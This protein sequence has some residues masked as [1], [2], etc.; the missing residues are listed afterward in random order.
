M[1]D[2][3]ILGIAKVAINYITFSSKAIIGGSTTQMLFVSSLHSD[4]TV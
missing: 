2:L 3:N 4:I 1:D